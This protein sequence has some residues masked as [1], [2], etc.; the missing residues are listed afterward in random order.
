L[1]SPNDLDERVSQHKAGTGYEFT[2]KY[3]INPLVYVEDFASVN[4]AIAREKEIK[5]WFRSKKVALIE[6]ANPTWDD[7]AATV[8]C[9]F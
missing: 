7:L 1:G 9:C 3:G 4:E 8:W 6:S 5:T 2:A